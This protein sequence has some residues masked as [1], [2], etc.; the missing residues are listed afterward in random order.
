MGAEFDVG[1]QSAPRRELELASYLGQIETGRIEAAGRGRFAAC[2]YGVS[3]RK[4]Q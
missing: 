2:I 3:T 4:C 1:R